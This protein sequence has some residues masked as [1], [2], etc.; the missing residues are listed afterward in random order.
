MTGAL[1]GVTPAAPA[2]P[3]PELRVLGAAP[4]RHAALP[5]LDFDVHVAE[6]S[7]LH[8]YLVALSVQVMIEPAR[9]AYD[10]PARERLAELFGPP[11]RWSMTSRNLLWAQL[12]AVVPGF[13]GA[14]TFRL[15]IVCSY[16][17]EIAAAKYFHSV[18]DGEVPLA[19]NFNGTIYSRDGDGR[20]QITLVPWSCSAEYRMPARLWRELIDAHYP[21]T[22]WIALRT[23]TLD[24]LAREKARRGAP[25]FDVCVA[26]LLEEERGR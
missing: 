13:T 21:G 23:E 17:H 12:D 16:D 18:R 14:T 24:A 3:E 26:Q 8:V 4:R 22:G 6:P 5:T 20:L 11:E 9:R 10:D 15:P 19:F 7:G 25:T 2:L 1:D